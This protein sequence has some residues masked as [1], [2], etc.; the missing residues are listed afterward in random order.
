MIVYFNGQYLPKQEAKISPDDRGFLFADGVYEVIR[1]YQGRLFQTDPHLQRLARSLRELQIGGP[2]P[3][4]FREVAQQ[5]LHHNQL[6]DS[7]ALVYIQVTRGAAPRRH[8]FPGSH[9]SPTVYATATPFNPPREKM[10]QGIKIILT[11]DLRWTRC[12][13]KS[14]SLLPNVLASQQ[15]QE[16]DAAEAVFV[17]DGALTEGTH[18][19]FAA[20]RNGQLV[21]YPKS[22]YILGGITREVVLSLCANLN[23]PVKEFPLLEKDL[24]SAEEMMLLGTTSEIMP[25]V[26]VNDWPVGDGQPGPITQKLQ[27]AFRRRVG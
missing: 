15:A 23:I 12:D 1:A 24:P 8:T 17:R 27:Q 18:T 7:D 4:I 5:L 11:P 6:G 10:E 2:D 25:V 26:R 16:S 21:T 9:V 13:I 19:N 14:V 22:H 20:V 3:E